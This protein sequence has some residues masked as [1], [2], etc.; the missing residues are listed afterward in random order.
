MAQVI[1]PLYLSSAE[2]DYL[3]AIARHD[4]PV[5]TSELARQLAVA[6]PSVT[7][8]VAKLASKGLVARVAHRPIEL[9]AVGTFRARQL[10]RRH[11]LIELFL[12]RVLN[13]SWDEVHD[14][15]HHLEHL[16]SEKFIERL[17]RFLGGPTAD[18]HGAPIPASDGSIAAGERV[19]LSELPIG[20]SAVIAE[21]ADADAG[22]LAYLGRNGLYPGVRI[23]VLDVVPFDGPI[24]LRLKGRKI[25]L[26]RRVGQVVWVR[27]MTSNSPD[28]ER[29]LQGHNE[30]A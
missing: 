26:G 10:L 30:I 23:Q 9:T 22:L 21:V 2:E 13:Y 27:E 14:E 19:P 7:G 8:M 16:V 3:L 1:Y 18:P 25:A 24:S 12:M 15:A 20:T 29:K 28:I 4:G 6:D 5:K 11:R 17:D